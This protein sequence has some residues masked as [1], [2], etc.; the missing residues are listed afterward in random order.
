VRLIRLVGLSLAALRFA[1]RGSPPRHA[2]RAPP[3]QLAKT[4]QAGNPGIGDPGPAAQE[5][6]FLLSS[7]FK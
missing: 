6:T 7:V 3:S 2:K 5:K 4:G 1:A